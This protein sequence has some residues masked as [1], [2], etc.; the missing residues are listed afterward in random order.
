M[1]VSY[2]GADEVAVDLFLRGKIGFLEIADCVEYAMA[3]VERLSCSTE[4]EIFYVDAE[5]RR[6]VLEYIR[7]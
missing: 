7:K 6:L 4:E 3:H 5:A 2:N 1:P